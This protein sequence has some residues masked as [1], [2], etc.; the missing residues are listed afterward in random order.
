MRGEFNSAPSPLFPA[1][2]GEEFKSATNQIGIAIILAVLLLCA[3][4]FARAASLDD[5][6]AKRK[7]EATIDLASKG[8]VQLIK[9]G[10]RYSDTK[11]VEVD[12]KAPGPDG[13]PGSTPNRAYD[14]TPHAGRGDFDD[15]KWEVIDPTSSTSGAA[16][17]NSPST[18]IASRSRSRNG[19]IFRD[20]RFDLVL[21]TAL[22]D[23]AEIWVDGEISRAAGQ[24]G[25][26]VI[27]G[28]NAENRLIIG[29]GVKPGQTIQLAIFGVNG[30]ISDPP[31]NYI[32]M[33]SAKLHFTNARRPHRGRTPRSECRRHRLDPPSTRSCRQPEDFEACRRL[34][35][36]RRTGV[37][38]GRLPLFSDPNA[39]II[40]RYG[41][42]RH[43]VRVPRAK[44]VRRK[45]HRR[46]PAAW[47]E[48]IGAR[49]PEHRLTINQ[50]G[51][52]RVVRL[53]KTAAHRA[54]RPL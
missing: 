33:K 20:D 23:Y 49:S 34:S 7:P 31:T 51:N 18:G 13:Q 9:G 22:D 19:R 21:S 41:A 47:L 11:I 30:P 14:F 27:K 15:S 36:H 40:Y 48:R 50:H 5:M 17:A 45:G 8:G 53:E 12:F 52:R 26:S 6:L 28:W 43:A 16:R 3:A 38:R 29:R 37:V 42:G 44:R 4:T 24:S 39:N 1:I 46:I 54:R 25:G 10:W 2:K 32:Y 35:V